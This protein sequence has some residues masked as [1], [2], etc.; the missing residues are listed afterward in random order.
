MS[1]TEIRN[2]RSLALHPTVGPDDAAWLHHLADRLCVNRHL[3]DEDIAYVAW[4]RAEAAY[5][6]NDCA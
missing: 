3:T 6:Q 2:L 5:A 4:L 1:L